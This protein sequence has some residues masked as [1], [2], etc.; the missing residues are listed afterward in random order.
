MKQVCRE[1]FQALGFL[2]GG[3]G[4]ALLSFMPDTLLARLRLRERVVLSRLWECGC[5][6]LGVERGSWVWLHLGVTRLDWCAE[7]HC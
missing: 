3:C 5:R 7:V 2:E 1:A 6:F 4:G